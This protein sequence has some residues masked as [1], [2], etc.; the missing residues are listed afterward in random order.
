MSL[1]RCVEPRALGPPAPADHPGVRPGDRVDLSQQCRSVGCDAFHQRGPDVR[2]AAAGGQAGQGVPVPVD[3]GDLG[4]VVGRG[5]TGRLQSAQLLRGRHPEQ[6]QHALER[7]PAALGAEHHLL[8]CVGV[9]ADLESSTDRVEDGARSQRWGSAQ[10]R[11]GGAAGVPHVARGSG[12]RA[13]GRD[14]VVHPGGH[15]QRAHQ[16][17]RRPVHTESHD[18]A[19]RAG[20]HDVRQR[21]RRQSC[22]RDQVRGPFALG[23]VEPARPRG[24]ARVEAARAAQLVC[25]PVGGAQHGADCGQVQARCRQRT[26]LGRAAQSRHRQPGPG[27]EVVGAHLP[28]EL[29][30]LGRPSGVVPCDQRRQWATVMAEQ[31]DAL[32]E[33]GDAD[34]VDRHSGTGGQCVAHGAQHHVEQQLRVDLGARGRGGPGHGRMGLGH[35]HGTGPSSQHSHLDRGRAE[36]HPKRH[37]PQRPQRHRR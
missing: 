32:G 25:H 22:P 1:L 21:S 13:V 29:S 23:E 14:M 17:G 6:A 33:G 27:A 20:D 36:V 2:P 11:L 10:E 7:V 31:H 12:A 15:H 37:R 24:Q 28:A 34:G 4:Q 26:H 3:V 9:P 16:R 19:A 35:R 5:R 8:R 30:G 18:A